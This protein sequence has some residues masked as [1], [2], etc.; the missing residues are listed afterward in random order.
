MVRL[1]T[2]PRKQ[3]PA[4]KTPLYKEIQTTIRNKS[5]VVVG[6]VNCPN[7]KWNMMHG[8]Q[9]CSR[10]FEMV[11]DFFLSQLVI[12]PRQVNN[13][14]DLVLTTDTKLVSECEVIEKLS[15]YDHHMIGF[16]I[17]T[18]HQLRK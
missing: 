8:N 7:I 3:H 1:Y 11:H 17:R 16:R 15:G 14:L 5:T 13:I 6:D 4:V 9:E 12:Q 10:F 2:D 18:N